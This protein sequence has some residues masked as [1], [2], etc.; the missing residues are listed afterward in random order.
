MEKRDADHVRERPNLGP[1]RHGRSK[2]VGVAFFHAELQFAGTDALD[3]ERRALR[4]LLKMTS[5]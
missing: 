3:R 2:V 4:R 5:A 1:E